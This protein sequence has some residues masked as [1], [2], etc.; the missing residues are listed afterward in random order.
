MPYPL[1]ENAPTPPYDGTEACSGGGWELF[2][3]KGREN[4]AGAKALC[5]ACPM[6]AACDAWSLVHEEFGFWAGKTAKERNQIRRERE[7]TLR[8]PEARGIRRPSVA[9]AEHLAIAA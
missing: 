8:R 2:F 9:P 3:T 4:I 5:G 1:T 6:L 7:I